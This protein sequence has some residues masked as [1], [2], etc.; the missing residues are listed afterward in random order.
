MFYCII[1]VVQHSAAR[2]IIH[3]NLNACLAVV[4]TSHR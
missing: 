1:D 2:I 4:I 3:I